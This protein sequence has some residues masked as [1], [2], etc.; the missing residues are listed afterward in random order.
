MITLGRPI[1]EDIEEN[2]V[3]I[4]QLGDHLA[5]DELYRG[6]QVCTFQL[7]RPTHHLPSSVL[8]DSIDAARAIGQGIQLIKD[9]AA[10]TPASYHKPK[11]YV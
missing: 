7:P 2:Q 6:Y 3:R 10:L 5:S 1:G 8:G 9:R 4:S 11:H